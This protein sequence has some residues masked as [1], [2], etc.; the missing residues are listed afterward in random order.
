MRLELHETG[1]SQ[2]KGTWV[3]AANIW[4]REPVGH[5]GPSGLHA[6]ITVEEEARST[7][8]RGKSS[9]SPA[10]AGVSSRSRR[11]RRTAAAG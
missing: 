1:Q 8:P 3:S 6:Q 11:T 10:R 2:V 9:R 5:D 7:S 4:E